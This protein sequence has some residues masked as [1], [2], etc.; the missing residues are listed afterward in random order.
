MSFE[1]MASVEESVFSWLWSDQDTEH[2]G[3]PVSCLLGRYCAMF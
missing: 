2:S 1:A 3:C